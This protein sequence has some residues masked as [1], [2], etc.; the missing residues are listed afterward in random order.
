MTCQARH[1][2]LHNQNVHALLAGLCML[3]NR[4]RE[5]V[6]LC[7]IQFNFLIMQDPMMDLTGLFSQPRIL[8]L[9][10]LSV[11]CM[12]VLGVAFFQNKWLKDKYRMPVR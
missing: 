8:S 7:G 3:T 5:P 9:V 2:S 1:L 6:P 11:Y 4:P 10:W 12:A